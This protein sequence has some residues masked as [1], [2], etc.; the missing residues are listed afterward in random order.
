MVIDYINIKLQSMEK[1]VD[2]D[3]NHLKQI[4]NL[5]HEIISDKTM[6][7]H[8]SLFKVIIIGDSGRCSVLWC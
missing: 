2:Y 4:E 8:D 6:S 3:Y 5:R 7:Y 1:S